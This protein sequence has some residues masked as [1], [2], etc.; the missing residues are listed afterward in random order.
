MCVFASLSL[1]FSCARSDLLFFFSSLCFFCVFLSP[2]RFLLS[3]LLAFLF[4]FLSLRFLVYAFL[5]QIALVCL[6]PPPLRVTGR[7]DE[8]LRV[9]AERIVDLAILSKRH[10]D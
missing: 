6:L 7:K 1:G 4:A 2:C 10:T 8:A 9:L 5:F 3:P